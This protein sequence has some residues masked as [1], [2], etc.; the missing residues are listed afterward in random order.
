MTDDEPSNPTGSEHNDGGLDIG[1]D[2][3]GSAPISLNKQRRD[4]SLEIDLLALLRE[5]EEESK[6]DP[7]N[8]ERGALTPADREFLLGQKE[9]DHPQTYTN[10]RQRIRERIANALLDFGLLP[11]HLGSEQRQ[12]IFAEMDDDKLAKSLTHLIY[13]LYTGLDRDDE[14]FA[15]LLEDGIYYAEQDD[16]FGG[17][18]LTGEIQD[19]DVSI[20]F[21]RRPDGDQLYERYQ[22]GEPLSDSEIGALVRSGRLSEDDLT[23]LPMYNGLIGL[24]MFS[25]RLWKFL[26]DKDPSRSHRIPSGK[27]LGIVTDEESDE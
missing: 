9:F 21:E 7:I 1:I 13:F 10:T 6:L 19:V 22:A 25:P 20:T 3:S 24:G 8:R 11:E 17:G 15:E 2:S 12:R 16:D 23:L 27:D 18:W 26:K 4:R 5:D 14:E